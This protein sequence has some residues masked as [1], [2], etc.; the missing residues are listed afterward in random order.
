MEFVKS[1]LISL[2]THP[3]F[4]EKWLQEQL[5][6]EPALLGLGDLILKGSERRQPRAGRLDL[7]FTDDSS[8][9]RYEVELQ[10]GATDD[11]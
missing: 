6:E 3:Y 1:K 4:N 9:T 5:I 11:T 2:K 10:L 8:S 7:L